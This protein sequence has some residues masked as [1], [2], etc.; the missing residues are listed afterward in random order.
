MDRAAYV[1][2]VAERAQQAGAEY[3]LNSR[4]TDIRITNEK[5]KITYRSC[6]KVAAHTCRIVILASG[7]GSPLLRMVGINGSKSEE[8]LVGCQVEADAPGPDR[9]RSLSRQGHDAQLI[10][11][12]CAALRVT[13]LVGM[14]PAAESMGRWK[15]L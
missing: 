7:F 11:V 9:N 13:R 5:A 10:R 6:N 2:S 3:I 14:A 15:P 8:Y 4:V 12:A 1:N